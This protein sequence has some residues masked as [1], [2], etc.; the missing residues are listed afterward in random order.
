MDDLEKIGQSLGRLLKKKR[1]AARDISV[2][3]HIE[4]EP[5]TQAIKDSGKQNLEAVELG[6]KRNAAALESAL[7]ILADS[8]GRSVFDGLSSIS[9]PKSNDDIAKRLAEV[10]ETLS[11]DDLI[12]SVNAIVK[13]LNLGVKATR[14]LS[15][16]ISKNTDAIK[17][18]TKAV[19]ADREMHYDDQNRVKRVKV[20]Q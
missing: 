6:G 5:L 12:K 7:L 20:I 15:T 14:L 17:E 4:I 16:E 11:K 13:E 9:D 18:N 2:E 8:L 19:L 10:V 3:T 1:D